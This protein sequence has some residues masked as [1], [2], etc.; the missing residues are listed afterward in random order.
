MF[1]VFVVLLFLIV[2]IFF[3]FILDLFIFW[4][5][6]IF[7]F[8]FWCICVFVIILIFFLLMILFFSSVFVIREGIRLICVCFL[9]YGVLSFIILIL[10]LNGCS[11]VVYSVVFCFF[12]MYEEFIRF[13]LI[14]VIDVFVFFIKEI[15]LLFMC[16]GM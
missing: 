13:F 3:G 4:L 16:F 1:I 5:N 8:V 14:K 12:K 7:L 6:N 9:K 15:F 11:M 10:V 2:L